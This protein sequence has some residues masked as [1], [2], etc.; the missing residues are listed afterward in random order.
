MKSN[1][2]QKVFI[3]LIII[4]LIGVSIVANSSSDESNIDSRSTTL[5][6]GGSGPGNYTTIQSAIDD[7]SSG[8]AVFVY[9]GTYYENVIVNKTI[10]LIGES[11][12]NTII[13]GKPIGT[14]IFILSDNVDVSNFYMINSRLGVNIWSKYNKVSDC[15]ICDMTFWGIH[16]SGASYNNIFN[17]TIINVTDSSQGVGIL[18]E[19]STNNKLIGNTVKN[20]N[21][22]IYI[23]G[24]SDNN[25]IYHNNF[26]TIGNT[27]IHG[28]NICDNGYPSGGNYWDDYTG[29]DVDADGIGDTPYNI[30]GGDNQDLY[31][32]MQPYGTGPVAIWHFDEGTGSIAYDSSG[33]NYDGTIHGAS[34]TNGI[35]QSSLDFDGNNDYIDL[36]PINQFTNVESDK[37][38]IEF[39]LNLDNYPGNHS[40]LYNI[41]QG[42]VAINTYPYQKSILIETFPDSSKILFRIWD[43]DGIPHNLTTPDLSINKWYHI[44]GTYDG[45]QQKIYLNGQKVNESTWSNTF[46]IISGFKLGRDYGWAAQYLDGKLDEFYI[47]DYA[48]TTSEIQLHYTQNAQ[49]PNTVY[50]DDDYTSSTP[51]WQYDHFDVIQDGIDAVAEDGTVYVY[52]GTYHENVLIDKSMDLIGEDKSNTFIEGSPSINTVII[53]NTNHVTVKSFSIFDGDYDV[54]HITSSSRITIDDCY[55]DAMGNAN[56]GIGTHTESQYITISNNT[57]RNADYQGIRLSETHHSTI[58]NNDV[59]NA[60]VNQIQIVN[61]CSYNTLYGN[62]LDGTTGS[63]ALDLRRYFVGTS[64]LFYHNIFIGTVASRG[65]KTSIWDLG[66]P[67]GGNYYSSYSGTDNFHGP[68][69]DIPGS[70][71]LGDSPYIISG[72]DLD[73]YPFI[74]QNGWLYNNPVVNFTYLP[75]NPTKLDVIQFNDTSYD[76]DGNVTEWHWEFGDGANST[77]R[78]ATHQYNQIGTYAVNLT[79][80]DNDGL[81][82]TIQKLITISNIPPVANYTYNPSNPS[83]DDDIYF[84]DNS[85]D[86]DGNIVDWHWE[87]GDGYISDVQNPIHCYH[88][89]GLFMINLTVIDNDGSVNT[90]SKII[91]VTNIEPFANFTYFPEEPTIID[92]INFF[93]IS[94]D[95]TIV[96]YTWDFG[97]GNISYLENPIHLYRNPGNYSVCLTVT[98]DVGASDTCCKSI[99]VT[100]PE[101][102]VDTNQE[103]FDRGFPIRYAIDGDWAGAQSFTPTIDTLTKLEIFLRKFGTPEFNLTVELREDT[104]DGTL[105]DI[106]SFTPA[107]VPSSWEWFELDFTDVLVQPGTDYFI[108]CPP[109]PSGVTTSFGFEWGYA[110]GN[111]YDDGSFWFTRDGGGLWRDLPTMYE[112]AFRTYGYDT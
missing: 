93:S 24:D 42:N 91:N 60:D 34:W 58:C 50:V 79:V 38:S 37:I 97:D 39:W 14:C 51:G 71:G 47:Y 80:K 73:Q 72:S 25:T 99:N 15:S 107:E 40:E 83:T 59:R 68:D 95:R 65:V 18:L 2:F 22:D 67:E 74:N 89:E 76:I 106:L 88:A 46:K 19:G 82:N 57:I 90:T 102:T 41:W 6:V 23:S 70:D 27:L 9:N 8:D 10:D 92:T 30:S 81:I 4:G 84:V 16:I 52:N 17:N 77:E 33:N 45:A 103:L 96:N 29:I 112:F 1:R 63:R 110:F 26:L 64:N 53:D 35:N 61:T 85:Y 44:V 69:Q 87:F 108:V 78:N 48:L 109:A 100:I 55:I 111:Q 66:Y 3:Y 28:N 11:K 49:I 43:V 7:A 5:Y 31:P 104:I 21:S 62:Y 75:Q 98:D 56:D 13:D 86:L 36:P 54:V 101:G 105:L 94:S 32:L 12:K 20:T